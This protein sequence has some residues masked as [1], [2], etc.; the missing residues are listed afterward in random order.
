MIGGAEEMADLVGAW[1]E[2]RNDGVR[3]KSWTSSEPLVDL[4]FILV[5][6]VS[7]SEIC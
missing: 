6:F 1:S 7:S 4:I 3:G 2:A 5:V